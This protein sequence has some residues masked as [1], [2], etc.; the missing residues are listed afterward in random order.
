MKKRGSIKWIL[1]LIISIWIIISTFFYFQHRIQ[2]DT[3]YIGKYIEFDE[4]SVL[5]K[6]VEKYNFEYKHRKYPDFLFNLKLPWNITKA[7]LKINYFYSKPYS[8]N[9]ESYK[10]NVNCEII[11]NPDSINKE[12][13]LDNINKMMS[14]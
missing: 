8:I 13:K 11:F 10:Y 6:N 12:D 9:K 3:Y 4:F 7:I 2:V 5:V 14:I 1:L